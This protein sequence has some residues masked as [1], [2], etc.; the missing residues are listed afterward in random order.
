MFDEVVPE[1]HGECERLGPDVFESDEFL[2]VGRVL[3]GSDAGGE[4]CEEDEDD[5]CPEQGSEVDPEAEEF[6]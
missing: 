4:L 5:E 2:S 3:R 1:S 6:G